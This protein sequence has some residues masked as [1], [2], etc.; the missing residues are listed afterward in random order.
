MLPEAADF[1][2]NWQA[3]QKARLAEGV[4]ADSYVYVH[5]NADDGIPHHVGIGY[6]IDRPWEMT[7]SR[8]KKHKNKVNKHGVRV[9]ILASDLTLEQACFWEIRWIAAL[10][11]A[12]H[13]LTNL[14]DGGEG[15]KG[16]KHPEED[17][18]RR[19]KMQSSTMSSLYASEHGAEIKKKISNTLVDFIQSPEGQIWR[20]EMS[21]IK[22]E[23]YESDEGKKLI[24]ENSF[25]RQEFLNSQNGAQWSE[26]HSAWWNTFLSTSAGD[27]WRKEQSDR[28]INFY[29]TD[30][31][32]DW[33]K[34]RSKNLQE[35][36]ATSEG[37]EW[38]KKQGGIIKN[39]MSKPSVRHN[40]MLRDWH[41]SFVKPYSYWGA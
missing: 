39:A 11:A 1:K 36:L 24:I 27:K 13:E 16:F 9:E 19:A 21:R 33:L 22:Q 34:N 37:V 12:G 7:A 31:G 8:N 18:L 20:D 32:K 5:L 40:L 29:A 28:L 38:C 10:R 6:T 23:F 25:H 35:F 15:T 4:E 26:N 30:E 17:V 14:T 3:A 2:R 41:K